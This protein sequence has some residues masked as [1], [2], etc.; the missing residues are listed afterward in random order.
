MILPSPINKWLNPELILLLKQESQDPSSLMPQT[1]KTNL[2]LLQVT[3]QL[4]LSIT[5]PCSQ[6]RITAL[7][8]RAAT[9]SAPQQLNTWK[10]AVC[11]HNHSAAPFTCSCC[12]FRLQFKTP[13]FVKAFLQTQP[14]E[15]CYWYHAQVPTAAKNTLPHYAYLCFFLV[16]SLET[17]PLSVLFSSL[18]LFKRQENTWRIPEQVLIKPNVL[19]SKITRK[20]PASSHERNPVDLF[21]EGAIWCFKEVWKYFLVFKVKMITAIDL[22][23]SPKSPPFLYC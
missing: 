22:R 14:T 2:I 17:S 21:N 7:A 16:L 13:L 4:V 5:M 19:Q 10:P 23:S 3:T 1:L 20:S 9:I 18:W 12:D 8:L 15:L 6:L 11:F